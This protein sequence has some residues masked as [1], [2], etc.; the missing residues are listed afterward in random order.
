MLFFPLADFTW[1]EWIPY[2]G[3]EYFLFFSPVFNIADSS[4]FLGVISILIFQ[5]K[6]FKENETTI[7]EE[8]QQP[9][10][11]IDPPSLP[12]TDLQPPISNL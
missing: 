5:K 3:G 8:H 1:P 2:L 12:T 6:F 10:S 4:I 9:A 7:A 11:S